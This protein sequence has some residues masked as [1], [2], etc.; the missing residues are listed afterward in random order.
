MSRPSYVDKVATE[1]WLNCWNFC[2]GERLKKLCLVCPY[3]Q[4]LC[5]P[6]LFQTQRVNAPFVEPD[7]WMSTTQDLHQKV[8]KLTKMA[9][10]THVMSVRTWHWRGSSSMEDLP[11]IF[12]LITHIDVLRDTWRRL[13]ATFT[14]T[15][16]SYQRL[17]RLDLCSIAIDPEFRVILSSLLMLRDL[18]LARCEIT[19]RVGALLPLRNFSFSGIHS[20][21]EAQIQIADPEMLQSLTLNVSFQSSSNDPVCVFSALAAHPLPLL[22]RL[23]I[24]LT[25]QLAETFVRFLDC[26]PALE[27]ITITSLSGTVMLPTLTDT[28]IPVL[29]HFRGPPA[30]AAL[31]MRNRPVTHIVIQSP[32]T[33]PA[34]GEAE[35]DTQTETLAFLQ[36]ISITSVA[37]QSL[38]N[39]KPLL[40]AHM[41]KVFAALSTLFPELHEFTTTLREAPRRAVSPVAADNDDDDDDDE[42]APEGPGYTEIDDRMVE[43][44][45]GSLADE[46]EITVL[47]DGVGRRRQRREIQL[48]P[49]PS[50][51]P[52]PP[53][54]LPVPG[55]MY[56]SPEAYPPAFDDLP[57]PRPAH[58][59]HR[60]MALIHKNRIVLPPRL[61]VLS[62]REYL[63]MRHELGRAE[64]HRAILALEALR[65]SLREIRF[66]SHSRWVRVRDVWTH[67]GNDW[68]SVY[69]WKTWR[70]VE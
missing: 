63:Y 26:C 15:L 60:M 65:P 22:V 39:D 18:A 64:E 59:L 52:T 9:A 1:I 23:W 14:A 56:I 53:P 70:R 36:D 29:K 8:H 68:A 46:E 50:P 17:T 7:G 49:S 69:N 45:D 28:A 30:F 54:V 38:S 35:V 51:P 24:S 27:Y 57:V 2:D 40:P 11:E 62:F 19:G 41:P 43:L 44:W 55:Y 42:D 12:P 48:S 34:E 13:E 4:T 25:D 66:R 67:T 5:Q 10:S 37:L 3:F 61:E 20:N 33:E 16:S 32:R 47:S 31:F 6:L 21:S 58:A